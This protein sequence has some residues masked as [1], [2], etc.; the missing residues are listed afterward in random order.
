MPDCVCRSEQMKGLHCLG[1]DGSL[2]DDESPP[3][4]GGRGVW[5]GMGRRLGSAQVAVSEMAERGEKEGD[6]DH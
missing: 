1:P 5:Q 2:L 6:K 4:R 3:V